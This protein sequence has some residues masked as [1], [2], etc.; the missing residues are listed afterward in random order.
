VRVD[1]AVHHAIGPLDQRPEFR[2][3][4]RVVQE[5]VFPV[6][7]VDKC[8]VQPGHHFSDLAD[9]DVADCKVVVRFLVVEFYEFSAFYQGDLNARFG[10][11][12]YE[13]FIHN[14]WYWFCTGRGIL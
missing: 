13:F 2:S 10:C 14:K 3:Q 12:D 6:A 5:S 9:Q 11:V 4:V 8:G 7:D 1:T